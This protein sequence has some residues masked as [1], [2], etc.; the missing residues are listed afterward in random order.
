MLTF[1]PVSSR[2]L[3]K[4]LGIN[5]ISHPKVC[6]YNCI[7]CQVGKTIRLTATPET[8]FEPEIIFNEVKNHLT[9]LK[10]ENFSDSYSCHDLIPAGAFTDAFHHFAELIV[11]EEVESVL[12]VALA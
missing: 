3:G 5:N 10:P 8:F 9:H 11:L 6:S 1:G 4:S 7:Y 12:S 2:R